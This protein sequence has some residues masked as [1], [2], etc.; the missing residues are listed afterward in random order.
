MEREK[1]REE[2]KHAE[3]KQRIFNACR[4]QCELDSHDA[5]DS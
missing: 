1:G 3:R 5:S 2:Q 4:W